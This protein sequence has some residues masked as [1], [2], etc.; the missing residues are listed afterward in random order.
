ML[1]TFIIYFP[2]HVSVLHI[3]YHQV[4]YRVRRKSAEVWSS[5]FVSVLTV[6]AR[7]FTVLLE[8]SE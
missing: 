7:D 4:E 2:L 5:G 8:D 3:D 1:Y 6:L